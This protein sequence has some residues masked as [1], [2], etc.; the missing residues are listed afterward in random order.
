[1]SSPNKPAGRLD[2]PALPPFL[3]VHEAARLILG[4]TAKRLSN[5]IAAGVLT[6]GVHYVRRRGLGT[7][8]RTDALIAWVEQGEAPGIAIPMA[9]DRRSRQRAR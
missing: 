3:R 8:I 4:V 5:M 1:M 9:R 6:E 7:R 2:V